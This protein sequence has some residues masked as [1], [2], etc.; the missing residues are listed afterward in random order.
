MWRDLYIFFFFRD[1]FG[2]NFSEP[3]IAIN[4]T[5]LYVDATVFVL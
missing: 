2:T 3:N 4:W 1:I 5:T